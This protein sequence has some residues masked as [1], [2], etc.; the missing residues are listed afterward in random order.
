[1]GNG[2]CTCAGGIMV[3]PSSRPNSGK[4]HVCDTPGSEPASG[5]S[6]AHQDSVTWEADWCSTELKVVGGSGSCINTII[7]GDMSEDDDDELGSASDLCRDDRTANL[8]RGQLNPGYP[9][10]ANDKWTV[11]VPMGKN[12]QENRPDIPTIADSPLN[13]PD[14][15]DSDY[16]D[17]NDLPPVDDANA[18]NAR[19]PRHLRRYQH[20]GAISSFLTLGQNGSRP[21]RLPNRS[22][23]SMRVRTTKD[24]ETSWKS[25]CDTSIPVERSVSM[26]IVRPVNSAVTSVSKWSDATCDDMTIGNRKYSTLEDFYTSDVDSLMTEELGSDIAEDLS[27]STNSLNTMTSGKGTSIDSQVSPGPYPHSIYPESQ[28]GSDRSD[29]VANSQYRP[30][31]AGRHR[32]A[33]FQ[34]KAS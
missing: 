12:G 21:A 1:M 4:G 20:E 32:S 27:G 7:A 28:F 34:V 8:I 14:A 30:K 16:D 3:M 33:P 29:S 15:E 25:L 9:S 24:D 10:S 13:V 6:T 17:P 11:T 2:I 26:R 23:W 22:S 31:A 5:R 18:R 19:P